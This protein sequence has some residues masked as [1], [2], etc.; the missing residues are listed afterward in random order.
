MS[1]A[2]N[3]L[4][5][6]LLFADRGLSRDEFIMGDRGDYN[7]DLNGDYLTQPDAEQWCLSNHNRQLASI[8]SNAQQQ[9][10]KETCGFSNCWIGATCTSYDLMDWDWSDGT[11]WDYTSWISNSPSTQYEDEFCVVAF[12]TSGNWYNVDCVDSLAL[13][14]CGEACPPTLTGFYWNKFDGEW[15]P[16]D[17]VTVG[18]ETVY[19]KWA[20]GESWYLWY[21]SPAWVIGRDY[22]NNY[23]W[24]W[25]RGE[26]MF[27]DAV[28]YYR[29]NS[30]VWNKHSTN[31]VLSCSAS[32]DAAAPFISES[33]W[34]G[35]IPND[36]VVV[37]V[38]STPP[39]PD[40]AGSGAVS[41]F[42][43]NGPFLSMMAG[44]AISAMVILAVVVAVFMK[45]RRNGVTKP[46]AETD[47]VEEEKVGGDGV[48]VTVT[49]N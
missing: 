17:G 29:D 31:P 25:K 18:D 5:I 47:G 21:S 48:A 8:H 13:P 34:D 19:F 24:G 15:E 12:A 9:L 45:R 36:T 28:W 41:P 11:V 1:T 49:M 42:A 35:V 4:A 32:T 46:D 20:Y 44:A 26:D 27:D 43:D 22:N 39:F 3:V 40:D 10:A 2:L 23:Y 38:D 37:D 30:Y 33:V 6:V 14:L 16:V 7:L